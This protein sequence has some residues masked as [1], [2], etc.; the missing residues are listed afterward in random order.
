MC[1]NNNLFKQTKGSSPL[2]RFGEYFMF[3]LTNCFECG[4]LHCL[5]VSYSRC[6][7]RKGYTI[8]GPSIEFANKGGSTHVKNR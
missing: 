5:K 2:K 1:V 3:A 7:I 6:T 4:F 8:N